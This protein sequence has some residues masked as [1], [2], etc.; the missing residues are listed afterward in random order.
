MARAPTKQPPEAER[1][2]RADA[3]RNR[4]QLLTAAHEAFS[5]HGADASFDDIARRAGVGIG[6]L[7]RHFPTRDALLVA[8]LEER[9]VAL[10]EKGRT[11]RDTEAPGDA[12]VAWVKALIKHVT[13]YRGLVTVTGAALHGVSV[14][15]DTAR[16]IGTDILARAQA[17][18]DVRRDFDY[19]D[20]ENMAVAVAFTTQQTATEPARARRLLTLF[21]DGLRPAGAAAK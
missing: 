14:A 16:G 3:R 8:T 17:S 7:Y 2:L 1:P 12:L 20:L 19:A 21:L 6:T 18:G 11:L 5:E 9:L 15:C 4:E 10:A 13:T